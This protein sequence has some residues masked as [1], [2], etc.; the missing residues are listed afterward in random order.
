MKNPFNHLVLFVTCVLI[1]SCEKLNFYEK[2]KSF[3][4]HVWRS[5]DSASFKFNIT[6]SGAQHQ[7]YLVFRHSDAYHFKNIWVEM[8]VQA[9]DSIYT[10][11]REFMLAN[12]TKWLG[13]GMSDIFEHRI[14]FSQSPFNLKP[15][16]YV[17]TLKQ[18][19]REDPLEN[20][21][22]VGIRVEKL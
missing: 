18:I 10:V 1:Y 3:P 8:H 21:A 15:G 9:P 19:M 13:T 22:N 14:P 11:T 17:F 4:Q 12:N 20:V 6:D 16:K 2:V 5:N 7:V